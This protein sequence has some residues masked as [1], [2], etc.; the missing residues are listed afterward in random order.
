M[1]ARGDSHEW[2][3][4]LTSESG[5]QESVDFA[6]TGSAGCCATGSFPARVRRAIATE[7]RSEVERILGEPEVPVLIEA[8]T[9]RV[10]IHHR[11]QSWSRA[12]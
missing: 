5:E 11:D 3:W 4:T 9:E 2:R 7:G 8:G 12:W 6:V 1:P 10:T